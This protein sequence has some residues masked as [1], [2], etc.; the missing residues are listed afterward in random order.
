MFL[1]KRHPRYLSLLYREKIIEGY[2][3]GI[4]AIAGLIA[5]GRGE[6]FD[7]LLGEKTHE[8]T[9]D[10]IRA[11]AAL[12]LTAKKPVIS[13]NGNFAILSGRE[14]VELSKEL[15]AKIEIN[16]FYRS[17]E[18]IRRIREYLINLGAKNVLGDENIV[19]IEGIKSERRKVCRD[20]IYSADVV[21]VAIEDGDRTEE[22]IRMNKKVIAIDLNP[23]SRTARYATITIVDNVVRA[24]PLL[25]KYVK[26]LKK[27]DK[28]YLEKILA[29]YDNQRYLKVMEEKIRHGIV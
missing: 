1:N 10:A 24:M 11:A 12:L 4:V 14:I 3:K 15:N 18:R 27:Y 16:L 5:H 2:L 8:E 20:G 21:L 17:E 29:K 22:L 7:Y 6:T 13:V 26:E 28:K 25:I 19:E 9:L 23:L